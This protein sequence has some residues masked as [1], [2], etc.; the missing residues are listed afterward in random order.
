LFIVVLTE[1]YVIKELR[2]T[3]RYS[4]TQVNIIVFTIQQRL[5]AQAGGIISYGWL[6]CKLQSIRLIVRCVMFDR[7]L[8]SDS[9]YFHSEIATEGLFTVR[10][11]C[12]LRATYSPTL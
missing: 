11:S 1:I 12:F 8:Y 2:I 5:G 6:H 4:L 9:W 10:N 7:R 3:Q